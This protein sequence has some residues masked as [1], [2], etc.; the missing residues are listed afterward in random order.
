MVLL[1]SKG[2]ISLYEPKGKILPEFSMLRMTHY[3]RSTLYHASNSRRLY[4]PQSHETS[5]G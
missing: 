1:D 4:V 3:R 2:A 5:W